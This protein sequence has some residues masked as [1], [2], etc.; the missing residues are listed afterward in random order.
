MKRLLI[1]NRNEIAVRIART[2]RLMGIEVFAAMASDENENELLAR[3]VHGLLRLPGAGSGAYL[4]ADALVALAVRHNCDAIHPGYGFLSESAVFARAC[5]AAGLKWIG[6]SPAHLE[7]F[8]EKIAARNLAIAQGVPVV[9]GS[10]VLGDASAAREWF[11]RLSGPVVLKAV[12]GG[13]GRGMR[14][15]RT[16]AEIDAMF[17]RAQSEA[18]TAFG[19]GELYMERLLERAR[20]I[21]VQILGDRAGRVVAFGERECTLQRRHQ[22]LIEIAPA[23]ELPEQT[24]AA[25]IHSA[26]KLAKSCA[27]TGV[28][29]FEFLLFRQA[30]ADATGSDRA[31]AS[32][33]AFIE[34]NARLQVEHTVT[35]TIY[36]IDLVQAQILLATGYTCDE[37]PGLP[38]E[39]AQQ[40]QPVSGHA[41]QMRINAERID[42]QGLAV[43]GTGVLKRFDL[44]GGPGVRVDTAACVGHEPAPGYDSLLA[45]LIVHRPGE[46]YQRALALAREALAALRV[47]GLATNQQFLQRLLDHP[48]VIAHRIYTRFVDDH[49]AELY[50]NA[51]DDEPNVTNMTGD[52]TM[53]RA[54]MRGRL[55][56]VFVTVGAQVRAGDELAVLEA[57]KMEHV[58]LAPRDGVVAAIYEPAGAAIDEQ[59]KII[60]LDHADSSAAVAANAENDS[61]D[62]AS[63][64]TRAEAREIR[65]DLQEVFERQAGILDAARPRAVAKR[66]KRGQRTARENI[67]DLCDAGSFQEYGGLALAAQ[68]GRRTIEELIQLSPAD[69][70]VAGIGA[71][72]GEI[73]SEQQARCATMA[74]DYTVFAGTQGAMN[75]KKTDRLLHVVR[76]LRLPFVVFAEGGGGRPGDTDVAVVA[77]LDLSTFRDYAALSGI[78]PRL[79]IASGRCFAG[80]AALFGCS[81]ITI[82]TQDA[83]IGMGGPVMIKGGG[84]GNFRAEDVGPADRQAQNGV[85]DVLVA[86]EVEA[87]RVAKQALSYFQ[88]D[89]KNFSCADQTALREAIPEARLRAYDVRRVID[90]L[91]DRHSV[92]E[93]RREFAPGIITALVRVGGRPMGLLANQ[94]GWLAGAI[95]AQGADKA[96][97]FL[98]L[99]DAFDLPVLSLCDTPGIMVGP[100]A[101]SEALVRHAAR[102]FLTAASLTVPVF[103][104][105]LRK[106]YGLGAMAMAGGGFHAPVFTVAWP[107]GE[108]GAM[109][110]EGAV[111]TGFQKEL[112]EIADWQE[113]EKYFSELVA[114]AYEQ[115]KALN[116]AG[117]LEIDDVIDPAASRDW[118][119]RG[120]ASLP[121]VVGWAART[122]K[123]R[124][125]D[126]W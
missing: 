30:T 98:Q 77:G 43:P 51:G 126:A 64:N 54:P 94:A 96:A 62:P 49:F 91:A 125:I 89:W 5:I 10:P 108:F 23:P 3:G 44:P 123:K 8:G 35:E 56:E 73:F 87:V 92:L 114:R 14:V 116:M 74:Y 28:G 29:T 61:G 113:R 76:D 57:M 97:R 65:R 118:I 4:D 109:G 106:G 20:H 42:A 45:K 32:A 50:A 63:A 53:V 15:V 83:T 70:L 31:S 37:I 100:E 47:E 120:L 85:V 102:L 24:R 68:R 39:S 11:E 71:V 48:D 26:L 124:T 81:D 58:L 112:A 101:E 86:D 82:A 110:L 59:Q 80:N 40:R 88:G 2:A 6:P 75:H 66:H 119:L 27:Y 105:V 7:I 104:I 13:G 72:N 41:I 69:G 121:P 107:T 17:A 103:T 95:D 60:S 84:L 34:A 122:T 19:S 52:A 99:C 78:A 90:V 25:L 33:F 117:F 111:R 22:K 1:A 36:G 115:G 46:D 12:A 38:G 18:K 67:D 16:A 9:E 21:E 55:L 79:A 93:L